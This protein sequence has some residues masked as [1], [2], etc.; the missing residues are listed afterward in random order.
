MFFKAQTNECHSSMTT[1][2]NVEQAVLLASH[3]SHLVFQSF[4]PELLY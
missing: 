3:K 1:A 4:H 2:V